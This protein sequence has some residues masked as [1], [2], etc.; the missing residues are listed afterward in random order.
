[1]ARFKAWTYEF[2]SQSEIN[3]FRI[4]QGQ[5][6]PQANS[7]C[8]QKSWLSVP[9]CQ[10]EI[11]RQSYGGERKRKESP[12]SFVR[13]G[14]TWASV[15]RTAPWT[16]L[17]AQ[18]VKNL[19]GVQETWVRSQGREEPLEK[20]MAAHSRLLAWRMP[21]TEEPGGLQT[22]GSQESDRTE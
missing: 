22:M 11:Q 2:K 20:G 8:F 12:Y 21:W 6:S 3:C 17:G 4:F 7:S 14:E 16:S 18:T 13:Q 10:T 1:M 15:S 9:E 5:G 19:P